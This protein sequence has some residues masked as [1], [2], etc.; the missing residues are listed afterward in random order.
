MK[1]DH[2]Y[3]G[4][5]MTVKA[6]ACSVQSFDFIVRSSYNFIYQKRVGV[7]HWQSRL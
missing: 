3:T 2:G 1:P 5:A 6:G 7:V 4:Q